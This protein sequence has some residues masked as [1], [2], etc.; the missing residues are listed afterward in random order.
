M[1]LQA[2]V[3]IYAFLVCVCTCSSK[4]PVRTHG[5]G[6]RGRLLI[7]T[8]RS[9]TLVF[10]GWRCCWELR[11]PQPSSLSLIRAPIK[12]CAAPL[13]SRGSEDNLLFP[14]LTSHSTRR[15]PRSIM[16]SSVLA[17][18]KTKMVHSKEKVC[19]CAAFPHDIIIS[20]D[21]TNLRT[22]EDQKNRA[23]HRTNCNSHCQ[24]VMWQCLGKE[25]AK[26]S[27]KSWI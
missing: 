23:T 6:Q 27:R 15:E 19:V 7:K 22:R 24:A 20:S 14:G 21:L 3:S 16:S 26:L 1:C 8:D 17:Q 2:L 13:L 10:P 18:Q 9:N 5:R 4:L 11:V 25:I 12:N